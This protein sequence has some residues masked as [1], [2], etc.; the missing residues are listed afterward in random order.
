MYD[1]QP[2]PDTKPSQK[3]LGVHVAIQRLMLSLAFCCTALYVE[4]PCSMIPC[5]DVVAKSYRLF[6][7]PNREILSIIHADTAELALQVGGIP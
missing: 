7:K 4:A 1:A 6:H 2:L 5:R 3:T